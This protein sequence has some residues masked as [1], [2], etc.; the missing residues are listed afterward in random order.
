MIMNIEHYIAEFEQF[1]DAWKH[2]LP[3]EICANTA[4]VV[5]GIRQHLGP[6]YIVHG[7]M[8]IHRSAIV[9]EGVIIKD[10]AIIGKGC[11]VSAHSYLREGIFLG[12][13]VKIGPHCEM[14]A[15]MIFS[16]S[17]LAHFNYVGNSLLGSHVNLEAGA[18]LANH[19]NERDDKDIPVC[20]EG[21]TQQTG[22]CKFGAV[23]GDYTKIGA[24]AVTTPGTILAKHSVVPRL[25]C[26]NQSEA[27]RVPLRVGASG[28]KPLET[29]SVIALRPHHLLDILRNYGHGRPFTPHPYGHALHSV[30]HHVLTD[31]DIGIQLILGADA[32]CQP[33]QHLQDDQTCQDMLPQLAHPLSKQVYNDTLDL[34]VFAYLGVSPGCI[35][36]FRTFLESVVAKLPGLEMIC[37]HPQ[38]SPEFRLRGLQQG[39]QKLG[40]RKT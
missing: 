16:Q 39:L 13:G 24:N 8:A 29:P 19:F 6:D 14:K 7:E 22:V 18:I 15:S 28:K 9:E 30:A 25:T 40:I 4:R 37:A 12:E 27:S 5:Q 11:I 35:V 34:R 36:S 26:I 31:L 38:E 23:L 21:V 10:P 33:C 32:I 2:A 1:D 17:A 20:I 3:W